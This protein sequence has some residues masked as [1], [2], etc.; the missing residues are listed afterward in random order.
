MKLIGT[1]TAR[2]VISETD[3]IAGNPQ[4]IPLFDGQFTTGYKVK[5]FYLWGSDFGGADNANIVGKLSKNDAGPTAAENFLRADNDN[6]IAWAGAGGG[7][8][9][10]TQSVAIVDPDNL[11]IEDLYVYAQTDATQADA[12]NYLVVMEKYEIDDWQGAL[13]MA[14][15]RAQGE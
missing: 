9:A 12:I 14:R 1:Y 6:E 4:K 7:V 11:V 10:F 15:D 3:T 13:G 2:G 8:A 5:E